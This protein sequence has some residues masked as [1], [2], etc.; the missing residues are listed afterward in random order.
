[1]STATRREAF[2]GDMGNYPWM[3]T[4]A[5]VRREDRLIALAEGHDPLAPW[6]EFGPV[7]GSVMWHIFHGTDDE[8]R[9]VW[10]LGL[11]EGHPRHPDFNPYTHDLEG[12]KL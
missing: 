6:C 9:A 3:A 12:R 5:D 4:P 10:A 1:M 8:D 11:Y 7:V 2:G